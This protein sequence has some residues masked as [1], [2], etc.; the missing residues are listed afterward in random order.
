MTAPP[1]MSVTGAA[2]PPVSPP[3][4]LPPQNA[5]DF[6]G[7]V[8]TYGF[9]PHGAPVVSAAWNVL[10]RPQSVSNKQSRRVIP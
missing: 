5:V 9:A 7:R 4:T 6:Y 8:H 2:R 10:R 1:A 3:V